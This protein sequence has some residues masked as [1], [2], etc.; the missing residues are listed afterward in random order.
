MKKALSYGLVFLAGWL[1]HRF[2]TTNPKA[3]KFFENAKKK[4]E[5]ILKGNKEKPAEN[6]EPE[7]TE[8]NK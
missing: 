1:G 6:P 3:K 2:C 7:T 4:G 5:E 8:E